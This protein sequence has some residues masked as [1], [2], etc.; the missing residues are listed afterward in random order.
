MNARAAS[1]FGTFLLLLLS[2]GCNDSR[3]PDQPSDL[4]KPS[5]HIAELVAD[6]RSNDRQIAFG[7]ATELGNLGPNA[8]AAI[9][10]LVDLATFD[11]KGSHRISPGL[12]AIEALSK[13]S[14]E[15]SVPYLIKALEQP[16]KRYWAARIL[17]DFGENARPAVSAL[18][19]ALR[20][21][22]TS[23]NADEE[24][25]SA[26]AAA[27]LMKIRPEGLSAL[28]SEMEHNSPEVRK[29]A[30]WAT[31][32]F[33]CTDAKPAVATLARCLS[34]QDPDIRRLA[35]NSLDNIG[36]DAE[37]ALFDLRWAIERERNAFTL[38]AMECAVKSIQGTGQE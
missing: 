34:D 22:T 23:Q 2:F 27:A 15:K 6:L 36:S 20:A 1:A 24:D 17:G 32:L 10:A 37:E 26:Q 13:I 25:A 5:G 7:A 33:S 12:A 35:A 29:L 16:R 28:I 18:V 21:V 11:D 3:P 4:P 14:E 19:E 30:V 9:P 8:V 31:A 38:H